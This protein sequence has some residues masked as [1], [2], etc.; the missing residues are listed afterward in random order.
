MLYDPYSHRYRILPKGCDYCLSPI[1]HSQARFYFVMTGHP[2]RTYR[3]ALK[4]KASGIPSGMHRSVAKL[5]HWNGKLMGW[6]IGCM[7]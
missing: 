1:F 5:R 4:T 3:I 6:F 2:N 7:D